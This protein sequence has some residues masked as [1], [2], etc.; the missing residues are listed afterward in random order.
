MEPPEL[1]APRIS[2]ILKV[3]VRGSGRMQPALGLGFGGAIGGVGSHAVGLEQ[4]GGIGHVRFLLGGLRG[5]Q[6]RSQ[7]SGTGSAVGVGGRGCTKNPE[8]IIVAQATQAC[9][10]ALY[11]FQRPCSPTESSSF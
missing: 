7:H 8:F 9:V 11:L 4:E 3:I 2:V 1:R 5:H 10:D 6:G